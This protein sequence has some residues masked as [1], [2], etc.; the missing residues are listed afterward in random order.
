MKLLAKTLQGLEPVLAEELRQL[1][2]NEIEVLKRAVRFDGDLAFLYRSNLELRSA[3]R[4]LWPIA[5]FRA[6]N[7]L[8]LYRKMQNIDWSEYMT[9]RQTLAV[10][11]VTFSEVFTHSKYIALKTKDAIVDQFRDRT[12]RRP[13]VNVAY[14]DLRINVHIRQTDVTVS[15]DTSGESLHKR[16][17]RKE[18]LEAPINEVLAAGILLHS[19]WKGERT[20]IDP[21]C[22]S[23]TFL[24][25]AASIAC[26]APAQWHRQQFA[27]QK[28]KNFDANLWEEVRKQAKAKQIL[29][30]KP[31]LGFDKSFQSIRV[32]ERNLQAANFDDFVTVKRRAFEKLIPPP[33]GGVLV[34]NPPYDE[35]LQVD[36]VEQ[37]YGM[38][39]DRLKKEF[40]GFE[41]WIISSNRDA[42]KNIGLRASAKVQM[43]NGALECRLMK[44]E[45]YEGSKKENKEA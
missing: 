2:A 10:D 12:G 22:G 27:F 8:D 15:I 44:Y 5:T 41:A 26:Q 18:I 6:R 39:G 30:Q 7:E 1:G 32:A 21:M 17:Y 3:I 29:P 25:E 38:I 16:G 45:M 11:G 35:R 33:G 43:Y 42:I 36:D 24:V 23:G 9:H 13:N 40:T 31:I 34:A 4:I 28:W 20:L 19:G 14:P 37:L